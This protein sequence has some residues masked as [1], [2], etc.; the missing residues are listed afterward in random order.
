M[1]T[2]EE[3]LEI[4]YSKKIIDISERLGSPCSESISMT[5]RDIFETVQNDKLRYV[6]D[7]EKLVSVRNTV[8]RNR[9]EYRRFFSGT[10]FE[11]MKIDLIGK[12]N[13]EDVIYMNLTRY[14][15]R[16]KGLASL[17]GILRSVFTYAYEE[18]MIADNIYQ[19]V[20]FKKFDGLIEPDIPVEK[21]VHSDFDLRRIMDYL[22][23]CQD[24]RPDYLPA[25]A[26]EMQ[27]LMGMRRGEI[28]PL[29][30]S[31]I[32]ADYIS[33]SKEQITVKRN[34]DEKEHYVIVNHTK[35]GRDRRFPISGNLRE[36]LIRF[37]KIHRHYYSDSSFL[38]PADNE[39]GVI[40]NCVVYNFYY[41]MCRKLGIRI[42]RDYIKGT[43]SFRRNAITDVVNSTNG[44]IILAS[45]IFGN[46]P[47]V[48]RRNYFSGADISLAVDALNSR[49]LYFEN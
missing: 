3:W 34:G 47:D 32:H 44:N 23:E 26:L 29:M 49:K 6:K 27:I 18:Y 28:P 10:D 4:G 1:M 17:K 31:D 8:N 30:A 15:L 9:S 46:S 19:R 13:I 5:F 12:K 33:I 11:G 48:A 21:R 39:N 36:F 2:V 14:S 38:F 43:H 35:N 22:H 41:R 45:Q 42:S 40:S 37:D 20:N 16:K 25:W 24:N 7:V